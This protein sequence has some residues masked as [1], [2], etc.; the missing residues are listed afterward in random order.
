MK[1]LRAMRGNEELNSEKGASVFM[2][3]IALFLLMGAAA[4]AIDLAAMRLDRS[5]DQKVT[6]SAASAGAL[7]L[8]Q[9]GD[10]GDACVA[11]LG[12]V[13]ANSPDIVGGTLV[14]PVTPSECAPLLGACDATTPARTTAPLSAGRYM[15]TVIHPVPDS[16][17]LMTSG[18]LG[19][20]T[21][22]IVPEDG[23]RCERIAVQ[24]SAVHDG[25][26]ASV[27][28]F[29]EGTTTVHTVARANNEPPDGTPINLLLLDRFGCQAL[30]VEGNG[31]VIVDAIYDPDNNV[32][33][34]GVAAVDSDGSNYGTPCDSAGTINVQGSNAL[35]RSDGPIDCLGEAGQSTHS[36]GLTKGHGCGLIQTVAPGT[37][38]C[39]GGGANL[40]AC[41]PGAGGANP[42]VP[43]ASALT[44]RLTRYP[45]DHRYNC[46]SDY[47]T[48]PMT[49]DWATEPL[50]VGNE[51]D[52]PGC[53]DGTAAFIHQLISDVGQTGAP[54]GIFAGTWNRWST[55][56]PCDIPSSHPTIDVAGNWWI[57]CG[58]LNVRTSVTISAGSVVADGDVSTTSSTGIL[59]IDNR[60]G[61]ADP[62][63]LFLRHG[64]L[65]KDAQA[66]LILLDT[67]VYATENS[68]VSMAG[69]DGTLNWQAPN[70]DGYQFDD[71][72]LWSDG[73]A[74]HFWAGQANL[75][76]SGVFFTP[77]AT[78]D[79][80]G[81]A[82]QNQ[83][84]AQF[85]ADRLVA[86][87]QGQ[88]V[89]APLFGH[90]VEFNPPPSSVLLR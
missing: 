35:L 6:D 36:S 89:V 74:T 31:G 86:R 65:L 85:I 14:D 55:S 73:L 8:F 30:Q 4:I 81:T 22:S 24:M 84:D 49:I 72:A 18:Q 77:L 51:Q 83:T 23:D 48:I 76:M 88:L 15:V 47:S 79:Y 50:T 62:G 5:A 37:P 67:T 2:V 40:P 54:S 16:H 34:P 39:A 32:L 60:S 9:G 66:S 38:G 75:T 26:F 29:N 17:A 58:V 82:G 27:L 10:G 68:N 11:A 41:T 64:T 59:N 1:L 33:I 13:E 87:G 28:G 53:S 78:A 19:A 70:I 45:I 56:F 52:I 21:Q 43:V 80:A 20:P 71:L 46:R 7:A 3:A 44:Q 63:F 90:S 25:L 57:D 42:P 61:G 12:Y 69:G